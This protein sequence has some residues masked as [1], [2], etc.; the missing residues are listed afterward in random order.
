[1]PIEKI[2][3]LEDDLIVR[4]TLEQQLRYRRYDVASASSIAGAQELMAKDNFDLII[5]DVRLP[6]GDGIE[7]LKQVNARPT[8]PIV[9]MVS[10]HGTVDMAVECMSNGAFT[11][12]T[13]PLLTEH[14]AVTLKKAEEH[15]AVGH[16]GEYVQ[17][18][19][20]SVEEMYLYFAIDFFFEVLEF[21]EMECFLLDVFSDFNC[22]V[23]V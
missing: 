4:K 20:F 15:D 8:K 12:L 3:V 7:F 5:V 23:D 19:S 13:K 1:M 16:T 17:V 22:Y 10:G 9:V 18:N 11:F 2:M 6:D 14:L 21:L